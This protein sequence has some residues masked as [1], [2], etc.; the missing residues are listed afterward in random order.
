MSL[1]VHLFDIRNDSF[2]C[3]AVSR[4]LGTQKVNTEFLSRNPHMITVKLHYHNI[5]L[6]DVL[7]Y[8]ISI[9]IRSFNLTYGQYFKMCYLGFIDNF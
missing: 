8:F 1:N 9:K 4:C 7:V 6:R 5:V 2:F 3:F